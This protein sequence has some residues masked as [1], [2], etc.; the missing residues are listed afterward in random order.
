MAWTS[1]NFVIWG[2]LHGLY[3]VIHKAILHKFPSVK[4]SIFLKTRSGKFISIVITQYFVF[5]VWIAF[6]VHDTNDMI[7]SMH[8]YLIWDMQIKGIQNFVTNHEFPIVLMF[9]FIT[10]HYLS[11][12]KIN[13]VEKLS[14]TKYRYWFLFLT[15]MILIILL[16]YAGNPENF[17]YFQF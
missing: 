14:N 7:Y 12:K 1:W 2:T 15:G 6:R 10:L 11:Y 5:L 9:L 16:F 13:F 4:N 8:K 17:I 3:L